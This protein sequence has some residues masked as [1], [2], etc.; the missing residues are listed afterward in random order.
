MVCPYT[1]CLYPHSCMLFYILGCRQVPLFGRLPPKRMDPIGSPR[2]CHLLAPDRSGSRAPMPCSPEHS[3]VGR[4]DV[5][6]SG[7]VI[8]KRPITMKRLP[9][10]IRNHSDVF[11]AGRWTRSLPT[12]PKI[13]LHHLA[14]SCYI[15]LIIHHSPPPTA[16]HHHN[17][18]P[19]MSRPPTGAHP[20]TTK[21]KLMTSSGAKRNSSF[22][23]SFSTCL[24]RQRDISRGAGWD[25]LWKSDAGKW[26]V[27]FGV[28]VILCLRQMICTIK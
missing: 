19:A 21:P 26:C 1:P 27:K 9:W 3:W 28:D 18:H 25:R 12:T 8:Y 6:W 7:V 22:A 23:S 4:W 17:Q 10:L 15:M 13:N 5:P 20:A 16:N 2:V 24:G 14:A 11:F